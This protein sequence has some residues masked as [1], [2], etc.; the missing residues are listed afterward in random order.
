[1]PA[2]TVSHADF[3]RGVARALAA[4]DPQ[5]AMPVDPSDAVRVMQVLDAARRSAEQGTVEHP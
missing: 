5:A 1:V 2:V 4:D 3:Y